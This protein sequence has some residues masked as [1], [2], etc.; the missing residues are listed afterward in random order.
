MKWILIGREITGVFQEIV[1]SP[2]IMVED[3]PESI[4][5][6]DAFIKNPV[7]IFRQIIGIQY[8]HPLLFRC[9]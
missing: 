2:E 5:G 7:A 6:G 8:R 4:Y 9:F 3:Q 1:V